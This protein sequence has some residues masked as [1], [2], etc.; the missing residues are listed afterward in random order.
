MY[1][2]TPD[3][4]LRAR[5]C[6]ERAIR[7]DPA[8]APPHGGLAHNVYYQALY[9]EAR[10]REIVPDAL[11]SLA[12]GLQLD[13]LAADAHVTR[14]VFSAFYEFNWP[15]AGESFARALQLDPASARVHSSR[16]LW[17]LLPT[18]QFDEALAEVTRS[19]QLDPLNPALR[20]TEMWVLQAIGADAAVA[21][22]RAAL[23]L[24]STRGL[25]NF[26][27]A[28]VFASRGLHDDAAVALERGL[29]MLPGNPHLRGYLAL[30]RR[31]QGRSADA[32]RIRSELERLAERRYV[33]RLPLALTSE[34][35]GDID[36][37]YRWLAEAVGEREPLAVGLLIGQRSHRQNDRRCAR[38]LGDMNLL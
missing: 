32:E 38:L 24:F 23:E 35:C 21:K 27:A 31:H 14:A 7:L 12:R 36:G 9:L 10:P 13:P 11:S 1:Q 37:S 8:Y 4:A 20:N 29:Q 16:S 6:Y 30:V 26:L 22:A 28:I 15:A 25:S 2:V 33:P 5:D 19:V 18:G 34:A 3:A 17:F